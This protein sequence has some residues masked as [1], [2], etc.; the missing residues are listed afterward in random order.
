LFALKRMSG[1]IRWW[2]I[3]I[4]FVLPLTLGTAALLVASQFRRKW[5]RVT[6]RIFGSVLM[7]AFLAAVAETAPYWWA[8]HLESKWAS[9][10]PTTRA[11]LES[12][13]SLYYQRDIQPSQSSWGHSYQLEPGERMTQ[14][15]LLYRAP[16]DV[17][18]TT[19]DTIVAIYTSYE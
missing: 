13:L 11:E 5:E 7:L 4:M 17:V 3:I 19:N 1:S 10:R 6:S 18:Y 12:F 9:A 16:L 15:R 8:L 2:P 14:Y